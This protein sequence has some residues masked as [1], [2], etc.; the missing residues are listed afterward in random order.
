[1]SEQKSFDYWDFFVRECERANDAPLYVQ[2][3]RGIS[4]DDELKE[5]ASHTKPGQPYANIILASVHYLLLRG[6]D[7]P[8]RRFYPN[9]NGGRQLAE[10][11]FPYF[12]DF[13]NIHR[14]EIDALIAGGVT[15]TNEVARCSTLHAGLR[16]VAKEAGEPLHLIEIGP[17]AGLNMIWDKYRVR[18]ARDAEEIFVGPS[19]APLTLD[20]ELRGDRLP[21]LGP[22]PRI[23]SRVG[24]ELNPVDL[25]D[26]YWRDWLRALVWPDQVARF[27]RLEKAIAIRLTE[28]LDIRA[29]DA[30]ALLPGAL[31]R[32]PE[33]EPVCVYHTYVTYQF[34]DAMREALD[35]IL[36]MAG[37]RRTLW[38][39]SAEGTLHSPG[40]APLIL[41][42]YH[43][44]VKDKR[45]LAL[46]HPH[47]R[48]LEWHG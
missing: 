36:I 48:W 4:K 33:H 23:A 18:Y 31:A 45:Q 28:T 26:P 41:R 43:D 14:A 7:H 29:G 32:I 17:S 21:P 35:N 42:T 12:K 15:N 19:D 39:L 9:L 1:M 30:L 2:I 37:L 34:S 11:A 16:V 13:V 22:S 25:S 40:D 27:L 46:C 5:I 38:R 8:L 47:G 24:L 10:D 20:C 6:A 3:V 44:G